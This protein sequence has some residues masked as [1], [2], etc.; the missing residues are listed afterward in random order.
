MSSTDFMVVSFSICIVYGVGL[1]LGSFNHSWSSF[2]M[3]LMPN[4]PSN[5]MSSMMILKA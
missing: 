4:P 2:V 5:K 3:M 1:R